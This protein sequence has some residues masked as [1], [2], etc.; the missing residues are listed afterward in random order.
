MNIIE[1][2]L[3][4][5]FVIR[6]LEFFISIATLER[7]IL[8]GRASKD[9][10]SRRDLF[11]MIEEKDRQVERLTIQNHAYRMRLEAVTCKPNSSV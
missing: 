1:T 8:S 10:M 7:L 11:K 4:Q 5:P 6:I 2:F 3:N 9:G